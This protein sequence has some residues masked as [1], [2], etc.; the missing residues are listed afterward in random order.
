M[1]D[2]QGTETRDL[3]SLEAAL[4]KANLCMWLTSIALNDGD[5]LGIKVEYLHVQRAII[6]TQRNI[7]K[8]D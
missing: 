6:E 7:S 4:L 2:P 3:F 1:R 8:R 5:T